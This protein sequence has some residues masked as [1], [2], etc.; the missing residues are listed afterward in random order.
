MGEDWGNDWG[1]DEGPLWELAK[2]AMRRRRFLALIAAGGAAAVLA[3]CGATETHNSSDTPIPSHI[4]T[5]DTK[6]RFILKNPAHFLVHD[7]KSWEAR[8]EIMQGQLT[9][10]HLFFVRNNS[11]SPDLNA[12]TWRLSLE[13]DAVS[14]P[15]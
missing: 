10:N 14:Y 1:N 2:P 12:E 9:P 11:V 5:S 4:V 15:I 6:S 3:A 13:G 8:L 7:E